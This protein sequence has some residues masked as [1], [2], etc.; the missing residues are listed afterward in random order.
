MP[1]EGI[2]HMCMQSL[3]AV[4]IRDNTKSAF[5]YNIFSGIRNMFPW[6]TKKKKEKKGFRLTPLAVPPVEARTHII[7]HRIVDNMNN[8]NKQQ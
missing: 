8:L 5:R 7:S 1:R 2:E 4:Q 6:P 3:A